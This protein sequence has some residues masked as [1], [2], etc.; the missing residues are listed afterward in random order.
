[1]I[2]PSTRASERAGCACRVCKYLGLFTKLRKKPFELNRQIT[3]ST[4][5]PMSRDMVSHEDTV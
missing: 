2:L 5:G 3:R 1:M 4:A